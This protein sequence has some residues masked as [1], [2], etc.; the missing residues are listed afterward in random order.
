M[1]ASIVHK[2]PGAILERLTRL[3]DALQTV[4]NNYEQ[5]ALRIRNKQL[6]ISLLGLAQESKQYA[7]ELIAH[8]ETLGG[9]LNDQFKG[10]FNR[11][12]ASSSQGYLALEEGKADLREMNLGEQ[13]L[14]KAYR[15]VLNEPF[16]Y[17][18]VRRIIR[19]QQNGLMHCFSQLKVLY[20]TILKTTVTD[21]EKT[22]AI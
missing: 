14:M 22:G 18:N 8:I 1:I 9:E 3:L 7:N 2:T 11:M 4:K 15:D 21:F 10:E 13:S 20:A 12:E 17:D 5:T 19:Y 16:L 6:R